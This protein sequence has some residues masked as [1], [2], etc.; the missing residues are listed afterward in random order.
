[1]KAVFDW[2]P[3]AEAGSEASLV[4]HSCGGAGPEVFSRQGVQLLAQLL[5]EFSLSKS[6]PLAHP[7]LHRQPAFVFIKYSAQ[8]F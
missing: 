1:M 8:Y 2:K 3:A 4:V 5:V 6:G 7:Y